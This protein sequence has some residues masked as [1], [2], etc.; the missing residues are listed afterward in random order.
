MLRRV[1]DRSP[2]MARFCIR[3]V[4]FVAICHGI[5]CQLFTVPT[6]FSGDPV[7]RG[8]NNLVAAGIGTKVLF[9]GG[10]GSQGLS[11]ANV[12]IYDYATGVW[13]QATL[14]QARVNLAAAAAGSKALFAGGQTGPVPSAVVDIF[15]AQT[16]IWTVSALSLA[17]YFLAGTANG[18]NVF[19][20]GGFPPASGPDSA[21]V[22]IYDVS[23]GQWTV[24]ALSAGRAFLA[25]AS[26]GP[27]ALFAG[28][29]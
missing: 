4:L 9:A 19:F 15:D 13:S 18:N 10:T 22:D 1:S 20:A 26:A 29:Y 28:E 5:A 8:R 24:S 6:S 27:K 17:R 12:D 14:S 25:A 3:V 7:L 2:F 21:V 11:S 23:T 16:G